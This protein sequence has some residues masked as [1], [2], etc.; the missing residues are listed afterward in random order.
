MRF[1]ALLVEE[2]L[3][4]LDTAALPGHLQIASTLKVE[5]GREIILY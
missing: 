1:L 2:L 4:A 3:I 5:V